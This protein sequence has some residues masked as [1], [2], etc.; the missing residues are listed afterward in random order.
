MAEDKKQNINEVTLKELREEFYKLRSF[1]ISN[2]WQRSIF[3]SAMIVLLFT[4]YGYMISEII[5]PQAQLLLINEICSGISIIGLVFSI[6]WVM[7][8]KGSKAWFE[9]Y[10]RRIC[11][12]EKEKELKICQKYAMQTAE[13]KPWSLNSNLLN[14]SAGAYSVSKLNIFIGQILVLIWLIVIIIHYVEIFNIMKHLEVIIKIGILKSISELY[15]FCFVMVTV[16]LRA[17]NSLLSKSER[18]YS[19]LESNALI[20]LV[21]LVIEIMMGNDYIGLINVVKN[22]SSSIYILLF[23]FVIVV[24]NCLNKSTLLSKLTGAYSVSRFNAFICQVLAIICAIDYNN[25]ELISNV[26]DSQAMNDIVILQLIP[27]LV[28]FIFVTAIM[29]CWAKSNSLE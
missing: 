24:L 23:C 22:P 16:N 12:I 17:K 26:H 18:A 4:G 1:E 25:I 8:A 14:G 10:E 19:R 27:I 28:L 3:L 7:M 9:V 2:L 13:C 21:I 11:E 15:L 29:N 5:R 20:I 6:I